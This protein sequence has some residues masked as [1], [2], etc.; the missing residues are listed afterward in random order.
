MRSRESVK[1]S[2]FLWLSLGSSSKLSSEN[3]VY[4][5]VFLGRDDA[6]LGKR[7]RAVLLTSPT[8][9]FLGVF[10]GVGS[11]PATVVVRDACRKD[12]L[13]CVVSS[14]QAVFVPSRSVVLS[15]EWDGTTPLL[16]PDGF[17]RGEGWIDPGGDNVPS[18]SS[19]CFRPP[20]RSAR[21]R[22]PDG[23]GGGGVVWESL[24]AR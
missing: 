19:L 7:V 22:K 6:G 24:A 1:I 18:S 5:L 17:F 2:I 15:S 3:P 21:A 14:G 8:A 16:R 20:A 4:F 12:C 11:I 23:L 13:R 10:A 9:F